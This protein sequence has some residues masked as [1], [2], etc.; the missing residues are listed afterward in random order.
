[1][2]EDYFT[3]EST[4]LT[5]SKRGALAIYC[6]DKP[7]KNDNGTTSIS[8]RAPLLLLPPDMFT[9]ENEALRKICALL[10]ENAH[11][12]FDSAEKPDD[13]SQAVLDVLAERARQ[14]SAE[15]WTQEHDDDHDPGDLATAAT[16]YAF[17]AATNLSPYDAG[18]D[19][20]PIFWP[21]DWGM[22]WWKPGSPRRDLVKA[23]ALI[24]AEIERL[25]RARA[26]KAKGDA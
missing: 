21:M 25:D 23:G 18:R 7:R 16:A 15:G 1:M 13:P 14:A 3:V 6:G 8:M 22:E 12:F 11:L 9:E 4:A 17:H 19:E 26:A 5:I 24:L 2:S 10:N 20:E